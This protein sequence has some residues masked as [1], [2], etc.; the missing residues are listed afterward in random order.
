[1]LKEALNLCR[2][3]GW[4]SWA[5]AGDWY[6]TDAESFKGEEAYWFLPILGVTVVDSAYQMFKLL[7]TI[8]K[9]YRERRAAPP[10]S[11]SCT[12][13]KTASVSTWSDPGK[14]TCAS[15]CVSFQRREFN[16]AAWSRSKASKPHD[17]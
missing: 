6:A 12:R 14:K 16:K 11:S 8:A 17:T 3:N 15:A 4:N 1:M 2:R 7:V 9:D 5:K 13:S 10:A